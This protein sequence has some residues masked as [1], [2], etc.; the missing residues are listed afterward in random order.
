[1]AAEATDRGQ[2]T[3]ATTPTTKKAVDLLK[4]TSPSRSTSAAPVHKYD[5]CRLDLV[6]LSPMCAGHLHPSPVHGDTLSGRDHLAAEQI[7]GI[8]G[9][10][11]Q[12]VSSRFNLAV[13]VLCKDADHECLVLVS[14]C[15]VCE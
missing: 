5:A 7:E 13:G 4:D 11:H 12:V 8:S 1:V 3:P 14:A 2:A 6:R 9:E 10:S 15:Q